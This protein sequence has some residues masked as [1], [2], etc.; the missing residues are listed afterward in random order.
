MIYPETNCEKIDCGEL[1]RVNCCSSLGPG[2]LPHPLMFYQPN[3]MPDPETLSRLC[4]ALWPSP[5]E[6][7]YVKYFV[8]YFLILLNYSRS[9]RYNQGSNWSLRYGI[10]AL[11]IFTN[12]WNLL[13]WLLCPLNGTS[14]IFSHLSLLTAS[15]R[16][17]Q[18][19]CH[20]LFE[21]KWQPTPV[22]LPGKSHGQ[23]SL[24]G[25][26]PEGRKES[27]TT[28]QFHIHSFIHSMECKPL[29]QSLC[30]A[31]V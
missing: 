2:K 23:R 21:P 15:C 16:A 9:Q 29:G 20:V 12:R 26:S 19:E 1:K 10:W 8:K 13:S 22:L 27:D 25:Y 14:C 18:F 6:R 17:A 3:C 30:L 7:I 28:E 11:K 31:C 4:P 24:V 5:L